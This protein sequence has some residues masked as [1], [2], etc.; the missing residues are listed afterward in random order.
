M[1]LFRQTIEGKKVKGMVIVC[2]D[3]KGGQYVGHWRINKPIIDYQK[4]ISCLLCVIYCPEAAI[5]SNEERQ[6]NID[7]RFC[8]GCGICAN[9]CPSK[10]IEMKKEES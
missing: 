8:K 5:R 1:A 7:M 10:A 2:R 6:P 4:C 9:E 3:K